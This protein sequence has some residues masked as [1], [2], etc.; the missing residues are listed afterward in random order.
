MTSL[1]K[2]PLKSSQNLDHCP[3]HN[4]LFTY[5]PIVSILLTTPQILLLQTCHSIQTLTMLIIYKQFHYR[6]DYWLETTVVFKN[7][8]HKPDN[9]HHN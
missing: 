9:F 2:G 4:K 5:Q 7:N 6:L 8:M 1:G 3:R